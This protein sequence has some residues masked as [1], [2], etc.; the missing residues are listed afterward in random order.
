MTRPRS[1]ASRT[2]AALLTLLAG[3]DGARASSP[4]HCNAAPASPLSFVPVPGHPF[5]TVLSR[6]GCWLFASLVTAGPRSA[7]GVAL[8]E[9]SGGE[10]RFRKL[11]AVEGQPTGMVMT[12][13][14]K[15][16]VVADDD[17]VVFMDVERMITGR[18]D[19]IL[20]F[21][22]DGDAPGSV[23]VNVTADDAFLFVSD[24]GA[25]AISVIDLRA[26][27]ANGFQASAIVGRIPVGSAPI[28]L[29]F[30]TDQRWLYTTSQ[31]APKTFGW[32]IECKPEGADPATAAP[33]YPQGVVFV[34]DV[35]RAR[36]DPAS[37]VVARIPAGCSPVRLAISPAGDRVYV[38][39]RNSNSLLA[40]DT[41]KFLSDSSGARVGT[42][43]VGR[44]PVGVAVVNGGT[45]VLVTNSD[46]F[47][48]D[49]KA[50]QALTVIDA[51]RVAQGAPAILGSLPAGAFPRE[52]GMSPDGATLFVANYESNEIEIVDLKWMP[53]E[54][55]KQAAPH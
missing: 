31:I 46:R 36:T 21:L 35:A 38:T 32:P 45:Q 44:S 6:D 33:R 40:F 12:H 7:N 25:S 17:F 13:D 29:T 50:R 55:A 18:G 42:V 11:F 5:S 27:R 53:I 28:A 20:G 8:F 39:A 23:Y 26:A 54:T 24:E 15:L 16:L 48:A 10:L 47:A 34:V 9:R 19:P 14:G 1:I 51:A 22:S 41:G 49:R 2:L 37:S 52:F 43:P 30:S 4:S 3:P